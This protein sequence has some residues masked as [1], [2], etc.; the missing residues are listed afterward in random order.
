MCVVFDWQEA[1]T[2]SWEEYEEAI[3]NLI[4]SER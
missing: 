1:G 3:E 2:V 4:E